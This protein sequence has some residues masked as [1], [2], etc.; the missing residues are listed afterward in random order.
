MHVS[1]NI[2]IQ[3][4]KTAMKKSYI[5]LLYI[6]IVIMSCKTEDKSLFDSKLVGEWN[7]DSLCS[8]NGVCVY[9][10]IDTW[11]K[12]KNSII[13]RISNNNEVEGV[14]YHRGFNGTLRILEINKNL[15]FSLK[16]DLT[17]VAFFYES[18][19]EP[20]CMG[21][22]NQSNMYEVKDDKILMIKSY[23]DTKTMYLTRK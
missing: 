23:Y 1:P 11:N 15:S 9:P 5:L 22:L 20:L 6:G 21:F 2:V 3:F 10:S 18:I 13:I 14:N 12:T 19:W 17:F 16:K 7:I 4:K 8:N